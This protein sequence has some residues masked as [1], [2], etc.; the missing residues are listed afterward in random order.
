MSEVRREVVLVEPDLASGRLEV[1]QEEV[2]AEVG[3]QVVVHLV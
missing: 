3:C 2:L 1:D